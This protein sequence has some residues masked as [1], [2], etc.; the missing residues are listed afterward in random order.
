[1][2]ELGLRMPFGGSRSQILAMVVKRALI[3]GVAGIVAGANTSILGGSLVSS[4]PFRVQP[5]HP[6]T[7][8]GVAA[9]L[10][11][12][13]VIAALAPALRAAYVNPL[14]TLGEN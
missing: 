14:Q 9:V 3:F 5:L 4:L 13:W 7:Y 10:L 6:S 12:V 1:M 2:R 11:A 8:V